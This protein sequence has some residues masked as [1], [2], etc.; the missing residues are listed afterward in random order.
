MEQDWVVIYS[1]DSAQS[2]LMIKAMLETNSIDAV[3]LDKQDSG[4]KIGDMEL[5]VRRENVMR[6]KYL[7]D[8][9]L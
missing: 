1:A 9:K 7:I 6:A 4:Y 8:K 5:Y 3:E 2:I